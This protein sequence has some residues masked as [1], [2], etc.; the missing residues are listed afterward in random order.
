VGS[1]EV[2]SDALES[3]GVPPAGVDSSAAPVTSAESVGVGAT[4]VGSVVGA[5]GAESV[6]AGAVGADSVDG[7]GAAG[8][9][10]AG[11][12][13]GSVDGAVGAGSVY[14]A[15]AG[16]VDG[17]VGAGSVDGAGAGSDVDVGAVDTSIPSEGTSAET[18]GS[19]ADAEGAAAKS[20][21]PAI[22]NAPPRRP[23]WRLWFRFSIERSRQSAK[24]RFPR[25][26][27]RPEYVQV[28]PTHAGR[29][30]AIAE[31]SQIL[32]QFAAFSLPHLRKWL[33]RFTQTSSARRTRLTA[34]GL[35]QV[36]RV[37][38]VIAP[39]SGVALVIRLLHGKVRHESIGRR[40]VPV[41]LI[42]LEAHGVARANDLDRTASSLYEAGA[43]GHMDHLTK[44]VAMPRG[45]RPG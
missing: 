33:P 5:D 18:D 21:A 30:Q 16:S 11:A 28:L 44:R 1:D 37:R 36:L 26:S 7:A 35:D 8:S 14:G 4:A 43:L 22:A 3:D 13:A 2:G 20:S 31:I 12:G 17:A 25:T 38:D 29:R 34:C 6:G 10:G 19:C 23:V 24:L 45:P 41:I 9:A 42:G 39:V 32:P 15:G 40:A 27:G